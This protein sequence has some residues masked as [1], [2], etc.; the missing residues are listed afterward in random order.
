MDLSTLWRDI[1]FW[2]GVVAGLGLIDR[3]MERQAG[4]T[5]FTRQLTMILLTATAAVAAWRKSRLPRG[6]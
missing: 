2:L 6:T 5:K 4:V 1:P 3:V